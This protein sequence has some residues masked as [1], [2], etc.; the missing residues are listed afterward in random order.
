MPIY[1]YRCTKNGHEFE[2]IQKFSDPPLKKCRHCGSKVEKLISVSSFVLKGSGFYV[3]DY[4]RKNGGH[5]KADEKADE[6]AKNNGTKKTADSNEKAS[7]SEKAG[8]AEKAGKG[9]KTKSAA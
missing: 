7:K 1:E 8:K 6:K 5:E 2:V 9:E 4:A 3:N